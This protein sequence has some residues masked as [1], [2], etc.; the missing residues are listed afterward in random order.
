MQSENTPDKLADAGQIDASCTED[1]GRKV[2]LLTQQLDGRTRAAT[3]AK[4]LARAIEVDL[5]GDLTAIQTEL[6][7]RFT[8]LAIWCEAQDVAAARGEPFDATQYA[9][10][11]NS[12]KRIGEALG[13]KR[14]ARPVE[15]LSAYLA[16]Q[17]AELTHHEP[18]LGDG[19]AIPT[20]PTES[21]T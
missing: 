4:S 10:I 15:S 21:N 6:V 2:R 20:P 13:L 18:P 14:V 16:R 8:A 11:A 19:E 5:G 3:K 9:A 7:R 17:A 1:T 12:L